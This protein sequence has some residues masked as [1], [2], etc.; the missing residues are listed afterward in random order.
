MMKRQISMRS[1]RRI[2][3]ISGFEMQSEY[4]TEAAI[5]HLC[6][7]E[8]KDTFLAFRSQNKAQER[9]RNQRKQCG[10]ENQTGGKRCVAVV[11]CGENR[12]C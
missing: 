12:R 3:W 9:E 6:I 8:Q 10:N 7:D 11:T 1:S 4:E 5:G 2:R